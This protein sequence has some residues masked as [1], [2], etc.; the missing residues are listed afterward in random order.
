MFQGRPLA[1]QTYHFFRTFGKWG[2]PCVQ[3][4]TVH[5]RSQF[6]LSRASK[7]FKPTGC[8]KELDILWHCQQVWLTRLQTCHSTLS[9]HQLYHWPECRN[10]WALRYSGLTLAKHFTIFDETARMSRVLWFSCVFTV[11][12][13]SQLTEEPLQWALNIEINETAGI[14]FLLNDA[15]SWM[16]FPCKLCIFLQQDPRCPTS[17]KQMVLKSSD[18]T[19][20]AYRF[21]R[22]HLWRR[23]LSVEPCRFWLWNWHIKESYV[24]LNEIFRCSKFCAFVPLSMT[25]NELF[26]VWHS[27]SDVPTWAKVFLVPLDVDSKLANWKY[28]QSKVTIRVPRA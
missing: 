9:W 14:I 10:L 19:S 12:P 13:L 11:T 20:F 5:L 18:S 27:C 28:E 1:W 15:G 25:K 3:R 24:C 8:H 6:S 16:H 17:L 23:R 22:F 21:A 7:W 2:T 26:R 4:T